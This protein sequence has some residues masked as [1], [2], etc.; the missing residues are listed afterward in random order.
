MCYVNYLPFLRNCD[1]QEHTGSRN[2]GH[3]KVVGGK[4]RVGG[5]VEVYRLPCCKKVGI[6]KRAGSEETE[7]GG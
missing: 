6:C 2:V 4:E 7:S 5:G 1:E 3:I